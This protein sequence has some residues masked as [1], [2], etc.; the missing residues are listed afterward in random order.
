LQKNE[1]RNRRRGGR[2]EAARSAAAAQAPAGGQAAA[3]SKR[4]AAGMKFFQP[5]G[6]FSSKRASLALVSQITCTF[7]ALYIIQRIMLTKVI[8]LRFSSTLDGF[9][10]TPLRDFIKDKE[11]VSMQNHFF[12]KND[13]P[14]LTIVI[15][16]TLKPVAA[17]KPAEN[18]IAGK[19]DESWRKRLTEADMPLFNALRDWRNRRSKREGFPPYIICTNDQLAE[20][21][22][23]RPQ[24]LAKLGEIEGF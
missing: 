15:N 13:S 3:G 5:S 11:V 2:S 18:Q 24:S 1:V 8:T 23:A 17:E 19:R 12:I 14:Y 16:Y 9:D 6:N 4:S 21:V 7:K 22:A 20:M 10:D